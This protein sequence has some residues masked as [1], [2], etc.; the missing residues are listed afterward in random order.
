LVCFAYN[1]PN[2]LTDVADLINYGRIADA[3]QKINGSVK[4]SGQVLKTLV[5]RRH[6]EIALY[7]YGDYGRLRG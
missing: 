6:D 2:K 7:L 3:M 4:S 1:A 5:D